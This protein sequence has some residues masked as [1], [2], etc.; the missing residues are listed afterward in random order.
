MVIR[1]MVQQFSPIT[2]VAGD[3]ARAPDG[4][5]L[6]FAQRVPER[7]QE[8][9]EA[10]A[11]SQACG[12]W[13]ERW[14]QALPKRHH[15]PGPT[16]WRPPWTLP[17]ARGWQTTTSPCAATDLQTRHRLMTPCTLVVLAALLAAR[18]WID[19]LE[20]RALRHDT[21]S[22]TSQHSRNLLLRELSAC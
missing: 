4:L 2:I 12:T 17:G 22:N 3:T 13:S 14:L 15:R 20:L 6:S 7:Q 10:V 18:G 1:Q 5:A 8:R 11:L 19:N 21:A 9:W 16:R